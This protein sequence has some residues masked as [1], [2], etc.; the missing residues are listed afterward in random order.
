MLTHRATRPCAFYKNQ[1]FDVVV[2]VIWGVLWWKI[3]SFICYFTQIWWKSKNFVCYFT[4][5]F[6]VCTRKLTG[7]CAVILQIT[8]I[9]GVWIFG[10]KYLKWFNHSCLNSSSCLMTGSYFKY[11]FCLI[12]CYS[13]C[14]SLLSSFCLCIKIFFL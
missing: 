3:K 2:W 13:F 11:S 10:K 9:S 14:Y 7:V 8:L 5:K 12:T 4:K 1:G 6:G